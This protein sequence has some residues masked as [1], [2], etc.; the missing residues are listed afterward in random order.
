MGLARRSNPGLAENA[1]QPTKRAPGA[2]GKG[3]AQKTSQ[4]IVSAIG[5]PG[6][7]I[8]SPEPI[9]PLPI[10]DL[11]RLPRDGSM[12]YGIGRVDASGRVA[13][14]EI[15]KVLGWRPGDRVDV[16]VAPRAIVMRSSPGGLVSVPQRPCVVIPG[17][18]RHHCGIRTG[19][20]VLL[21]AAPDH[22][23]V[24]VHTLSDLDDMLS[25]FHAS[26]SQAS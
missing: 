23:V 15:V 6:P 8:G 24:I 10:P 22:G 18:I 21:A 1:W 4:Q 13:N 3:D 5:L 26:R 19:D 20:H 2:P 25:D 9:C 11:H 16:I 14:H 12:L 7:R 17:T